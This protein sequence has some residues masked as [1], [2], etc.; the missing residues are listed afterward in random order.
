ME[1]VAMYV[2]VFD[3]YLDRLIFCHKTYRSS[4]W[5]G[6]VRY[7]RTSRAFEASFKEEGST[8]IWS[9]WRWRAPKQQDIEEDDP[10]LALVIQESL[11]VHKEASDLQHV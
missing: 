1:E 3:S 9:W 7:S 4:T 6:L 11:V 2:S 10:A 8:F 5:N